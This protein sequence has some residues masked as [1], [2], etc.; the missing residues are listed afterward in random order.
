MRV[1]EEPGKGMPAGY[2]SDGMPLLEVLVE[3][4]VRE[5]LVFLELEQLAATSVKASTKG[6]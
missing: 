3:L 5:L 1:V 6:R 4:G 2:V